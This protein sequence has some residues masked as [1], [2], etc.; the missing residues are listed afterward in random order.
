MPRTATDI[1]WLSNI[2]RSE[3]SGDSGIASLAYLLSIT[4]DEAGELFDAALP[5]IWSLCGKEKPFGEV[6]TQA[7]ITGIELGV[8]AERLRQEGRRA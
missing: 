1:R 4:E 5:F 6:A 7:L 3:S 2:L 8:A